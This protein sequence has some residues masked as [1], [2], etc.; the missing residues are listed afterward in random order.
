MVISPTF[1]PEFAFASAFIPPEMRWLIRLASN[2]DLPGAT[3]HWTNQAICRQCKHAMQT[4]ATIDSFAGN[5]GLAAFQCADCG[6][7]D[8]VLVYPSKRIWEN[9]HMQPREKVPNFA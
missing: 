7:T 2:N 1:R 6:A 5:P 8:S 9:T 4:V 3:M